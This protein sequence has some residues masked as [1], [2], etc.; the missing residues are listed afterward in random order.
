MVYKAKAESVKDNLKII[1]HAAGVIFI[2]LIFFTWKCGGKPSSISGVIEAKDSIIAMQQRQIDELKIDN[3]GLDAT[4]AGRDTRDSLF[5]EYFKKRPQVYKKLNDQLKDIPG[6]I[7]A[8]AG[9][10][11]AIN[12]ALSK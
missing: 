6:R 1:L 3:K 12:D 4:I 11:S 2:A 8:I 5:M 7:A 9:S 10:D